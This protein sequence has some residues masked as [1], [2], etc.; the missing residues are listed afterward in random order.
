MG[1]VAGMVTIF[2]LLVDHISGAGWILSGVAACMLTSFFVFIAMKA[3]RNKRAIVGY[4]VLQLF[5]LAACDIT[6][7]AC[8]YPHG[9]YA[10]NG[11]V[12][13]YMF[14]LLPL[15][16]ILACTLLSRYNMKRRGG[17]QIPL[18]GK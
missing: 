3:N 8:S 6:W 13:I 2:R 15:L 14:L 9:E 1:G 10:N 5:V 7:L 17:K 18:S 11:I 12:S 4:I 16:N